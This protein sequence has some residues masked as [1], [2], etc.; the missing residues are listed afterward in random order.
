MFEGTSWGS[1]GSRPEGQNLKQTRAVT[2]MRAGTVI[3]NA[4]T[5]GPYESTFIVAFNV[6]LTSMIAGVVMRQSRRLNYVKYLDGE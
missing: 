1:L 4:V 2:A 5:D 3:V 6:V